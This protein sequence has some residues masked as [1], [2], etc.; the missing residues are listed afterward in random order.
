MISGLA[1]VAYAIIGLKIVLI[2][3]SVFIMITYIKV[4]IKSLYDKMLIIPVMIMYVNDG[5]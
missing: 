4:C 3:L 5:M 2:P 1:F